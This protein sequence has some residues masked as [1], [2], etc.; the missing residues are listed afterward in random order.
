MADEARLRRMRH[1]IDQLE[2]PDAF[3]RREAI[4]ALALATQERHGFAWRGD[5]DDRAESVKRWRQWIARE[6][7]RQKTARMQAALQ[8][9]ASGQGDAKTVGELLAAIPG[10]D[11]SGLPVEMAAFVSAAAAAAQEKR[12]GRHAACAVCEKRPATVRITHKD[13]VGAW[14]MTAACEVCQKRV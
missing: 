3:E 6:E 10:S 9:L 5:G 13:S 8:K 1:L 7:A 2:S 14:T 4:E 11:K 12:S